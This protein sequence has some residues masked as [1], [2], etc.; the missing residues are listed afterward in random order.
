MDNSFYSS[1]SSDLDLGYD[2]DSLLD[3]D[4]DFS[5]ISEDDSTL[6]TSEGNLHANPE[7]PVQVIAV[8][9]TV[10][11]VYKPAKSSVTKL[12]KKKV[13]KKGILDIKAMIKDNKLP[14]I[15][16]RVKGLELVAFPSFDKCDSLVFMPHSMS[17]MMNSGD[18][19]GL[20]S[21]L[22][23]HATKN[24]SVFMKGNNLFLE[25]FLQLNELITELHPDT[26]SCVHNTRVVGNTIQATMF[27]KF[28]DSESIFNCVARTKANDP[29]FNKLMG[30]PDACVSTTRRSRLTKK[31]EPMTTRTPEEKAQMIAVASSTAEDLVIFSNVYLKLTFDDATRKV[32]RIDY[33][34]EYTSMTT[35][36]ARKQ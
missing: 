22:A 14:N 19:R 12:Q 26:V 25:G 8:E 13:T 1:S 11:V 15:S 16:R 5:D 31:I 21:L 6:S 3:F 28:T 17:R 23:V 20:A 9:E 7:S 30:G 29:F 36:Q 35:A 2:A 4:F 18:V 10:K 24:C 33:D 32:T 34:F 27:T